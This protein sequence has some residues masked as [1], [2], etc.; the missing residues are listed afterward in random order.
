[1]S[2]LA[3]Q[4]LPYLAILISIV[5]LVISLRSSL[6]DRNIV[7]AESKFFLGRHR[8]HEPPSFSVS[9]INKGRRPV[10][11]RLLGGTTNT[12]LSS[13][14]FIECEKGG[15]RLAENERHDQRFGMEDLVYNDPEGEFGEYAELWIEDTLGRRFVVKNSRKHLEQYW[16]NWKELRK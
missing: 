11:I 1:M 14:A 10:I 6:L 7:E 13:G 9:V 12:G 3:Q 16:I 15:K 2:D 4:W 5:S 8:Q